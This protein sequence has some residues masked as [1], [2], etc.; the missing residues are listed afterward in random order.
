MKIIF[1]INKVPIRLTEKRWLHIT[2]EHSE[3]AGYYYDA[4]ETISAPDAVYAGKSGECIAL[5]ILS[6]GKSIVVVYKEVN[7]TDGFVITAF[8][9]SKIKQF[10]R[11]AKLW[12]L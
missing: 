6:T 4:I 10:E 2:E 7:D 8:I 5:K 1:S 3:I 11:R 9:T 12:P